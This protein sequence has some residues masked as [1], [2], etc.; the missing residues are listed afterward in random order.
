MASICLDFFSYDFCVPKTVISIR[1]SKNGSCY[2]IIDCTTG[3]STTSL[4]SPNFRLRSLR[5]LLPNPRI[6]K[7]ESRAISHWE[8]KLPKI[9]P[10][11]WE[12]PPPPAI[13]IARTILGQNEAAALEAINTRFQLPPPSL[14]NAIGRREK[15]MR[16]GLI[17]LIP[18]AQFSSHSHPS[19]PRSLVPSPNC[20]GPFLLSLSP[21]ATTAKQYSWSQSRRCIFLF[22][23]SPHIKS[24]SCSPHYCVHIHIPYSRCDIKREME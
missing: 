18:V 6:Q 3:T 7:K 12:D 24:L 14:G 15:R 5:A 11:K 13:L 1:L 8:H 16:G 21:L 2:A 23:L 19:P 10:K 9:E 17:S 22:C 20:Q 4:L